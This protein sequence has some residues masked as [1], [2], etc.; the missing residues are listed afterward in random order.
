MSQNARE[1]LSCLLRGWVILVRMV[2]IC[3][4]NN[5]DRMSRDQTCTDMFTVYGNGKTFI[6]FLKFQ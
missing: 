4:N 1:Q 3:T 2:P 6:E 5:N